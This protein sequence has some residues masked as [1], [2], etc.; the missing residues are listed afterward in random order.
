MSHSYQ[1]NM[2]AGIMHFCRA[3]LSPSQLQGDC[4]PPARKLFTRFRV[5]GFPSV[6][7][8]R[9]YI[10]ILKG[11]TAYS[12]GNHDEAIRLLRRAIEVE[13][14]NLAVL[15]ILLDGVTGKRTAR[16]IKQRAYQLRQVQFGERAGKGVAY[17]ELSGFKGFIQSSDLAEEYSG[18]IPNILRLINYFNWTGVRN[19]VRLLKNVNSGNSC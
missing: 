14:C 10:L 16:G 8:K 19:R 9:V 2:K 1:R 15:P 17:L 12:T 13:R 18:S 4:W 11:C 7:V 3:Y 5:D 6:Q